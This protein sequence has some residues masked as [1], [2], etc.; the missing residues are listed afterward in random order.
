ME[1]ICKKL[2]TPCLFDKKAELNFEGLV[3]LANLVDS[4]SAPIYTYYLLNVFNK[5]VELLVDILSP[6]EL[7]T[8]RLTSE[9]MNNLV[10][11]LGR[12]SNRWQGSNAYDQKW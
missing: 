12:I 4:L 2:V 6:V 5:I 8:Y 10:Y 11:C 9:T 3:Q 1:V 7:G